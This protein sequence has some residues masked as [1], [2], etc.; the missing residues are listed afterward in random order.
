MRLTKIEMKGLPYIVDQFGISKAAVTSQTNNQVT[1]IV[2]P[3]D[4]L[5]K[6]AKKYSTTV[7]AIL[8]SNIERIKNPNLIQ[9]G[10]SLVIPN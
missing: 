2:M 3:G 9:V 1:Y 5:W 6:I 8:K 4:A 10:Q 7:E